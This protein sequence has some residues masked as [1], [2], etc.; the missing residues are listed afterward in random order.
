[1]YFRR[2]STDN[3]Q[4]SR[5]VSNELKTMRLKEVNQDKNLIR[6]LATKHGVDY[7]TSFKIIKGYGQ[8][9]N[10]GKLVDD[11][12]NKTSSETGIEK[13]RLASLLLDFKTVENLIDLEDASARLDDEEDARSEA[14]Q[15]NADS[16]P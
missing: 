2:K 14:D 12:I 3:K 5:D 10:D 13:S 16:R 1:M 8:Y 4:G 15:M 7:K 6:L 11:L 9:D